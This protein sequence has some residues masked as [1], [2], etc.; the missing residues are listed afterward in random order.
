[1]GEQK[2]SARKAHGP[3]VLCGLAD[4]AHIVAIKERVCDANHAAFLFNPLD[5]PANMLISLGDNLEQIHIDGVDLSHPSAV[6]LR[7]LHQSPNSYGSDN[8]QEMQR[9]WRRTL[10]KYRERNTMLEAI[11]YRWEALGVPIYNAPSTSCNITKPFQ[12]ALL[13]KAGLPVPRTVWTNDPAE[14]T[15][16]AISDPVIYKPVSGGANTRKLMP[17]DLSSE[18]LGK[19]AAAPVTFQELLPGEDIR[20]YVLDEKVIA[21]YR[22]ASDAVDYRQ[23]EQSIESIT[24][25]EDT[26][27]HCIAACRVLG[28]RFTGMDLKRDKEGNLRILELNPSPMFLGFDGLTGTDIGGRLAMALMDHA[29]ASA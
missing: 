17:G 11:L 19:L 21:S 7:S 28:L 14:V 5:F 20:V 6:Y 24:L 16:F 23:N 2:Q 22:I 3:I 27:A 26:E 8:E 25:G 9:D 18:R 15:S 1:V 10:L 12:M 13:A 29:Q 4:D